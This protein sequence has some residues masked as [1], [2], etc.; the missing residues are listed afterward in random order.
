MAKIH[1]TALVDPAAKLADDVEIGPYCIVGPNVEM[2]SGCRLISQC[3]VIGR[4]IMGKNN[5]VHS[6]ANIGG[7]PQDYHYD[8]QMVS[9]LRIGDNNIF[10]EYF[11]ANS[12]TQENEATIIGND[13]F[14]LAYTHVAHDCIV[15]NGIVMVN[16]SGLTGHVQV[17]DNCLISGL[18]GVHQ[19]CRVGR[20][21]VLSGGSQSSMDI[22]PFMIADGRNGGIR[23]V[24]LVGLKRRGFSTA[25]I[26]VI[27]NMYD[28][29]FRSGLNTTNA[30]K[31]IEA[32][33]PQIPEVE[34]FVTFV[35]TTKRGILQGR[36]ATR[37]A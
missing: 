11:T 12:A 26:R 20:M 29:M 18:S 4:T 10:R 35:R 24:N 9:Y 23:G 13:N 3:N 6:F 36:G 17:G 1:P 28:I 31:R 27:K 22:P 32:E 34:E 19:F 7:Q 8:P 2:G 30:L 16:F 15:G 21:A 5:I 14:F 25:T 37:R 33:L